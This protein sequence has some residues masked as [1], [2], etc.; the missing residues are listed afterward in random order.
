MEIDHLTF[1]ANKNLDPLFEHGMRLIE[2]QYNNSR[3]T[4][5]AGCDKSV[6]FRSKND[7]LRGLHILILDDT[8][9]ICIKPCIP[10]TRLSSVASP[11]KP[12]QNFQRYLLTYSSRLPQFHFTRVCVCTQIV[13]VL[14]ALLFLGNLKHAI[15]I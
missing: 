15:V 10:R 6:E 3:L 7:G 11:N 2:I 8:L 13:S 1:S 9:R 14:C 5:E 12:L 4:C